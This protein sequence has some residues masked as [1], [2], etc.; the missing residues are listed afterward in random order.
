MGKSTLFGNISG[1]LLLTVA[2][3]IRLMG[4]VEG[5]LNYQAKLFTSK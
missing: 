5:W 3:L 2:G 4:E 1:L